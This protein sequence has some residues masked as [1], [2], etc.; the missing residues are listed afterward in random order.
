VEDGISPDYLKKK[1][2][3]KLREILKTI[4][5]LYSKNKEQLP[6]LL[7]LNENKISYLIKSSTCNNIRL[8]LLDYR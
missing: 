3:G 7:E 4:K 6:R 1:V 8:S 5:F 2:E